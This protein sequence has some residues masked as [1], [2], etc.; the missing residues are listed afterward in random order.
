MDSNNTESYHKFI[1]HKHA[2]SLVK[3][4]FKLFLYT[5]GFFGN[6]MTI[7]IWR[8]TVKKNALA[9][10]FVYL[11]AS[12]TIFCLT[13]IIFVSYT[14]S[15]QLGQLNVFLVFL[16]LRL[17][18]VHSLHVTL[19]MA[20][21]RWYVLFEPVKN[22]TYLTMKVIRISAVLASVYTISLILGFNKE[23]KNHIVDN[24]VKTGIKYKMYLNLTNILPAVLIALFGIGIVCLIFLRRK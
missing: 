3:T 21:S 12:D 22:V 16:A 9:F 8:H 24:G 5:F 7:L 18:V 20:V 17:F 13:C 19:V 15:R 11:A 14:I 10:L 23:V 2:D 4:G 6:S 1:A